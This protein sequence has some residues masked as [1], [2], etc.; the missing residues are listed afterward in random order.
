MYRTEAILEEDGGSAVLA[1]AKHLEKDDAL[2]QRIAQGAHA[3]AVNVLTTHNVELFMLELLKR[4]SQLMRFKVSLHP[5]AI[6]IETSLMGPRFRQF[7][8]RTCPLCSS[9]DF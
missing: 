2:A 7:E 5:D 8:D 9:E 1:A 6:P 4:Y 3:L